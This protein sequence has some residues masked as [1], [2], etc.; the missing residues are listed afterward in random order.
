MRLPT[1]FTALRY[2][3]YRR[4]FIGQAL[5]LMGTWMQSVAQGWLVYEITGSK[6]ALGTISFAGSIPTLLLMLPAGVVADRLPRRKLLIATQTGMMLFAF[7]LAALAG[8]GVL[9]VWHIAVLAFLGGVANSFDAPARMALAVEMVDDR[10]DLQNAIALNATMF[11]LG[12]VLGPAIGGIILAALG[13]AWCFAI[14]GLS[15]VAVLVALAGMR[16]NERARPASKE[17]MIQQMKIGL[18][19]VWNHTALRTIMFLVAV[20]SIFGFS[21]SVLMPAYAADILQV[22]EAGLGGLNAAV[23]GGALIGSLVVASL[24]RSE[25]KGAQLTFGSLLFPVAVVAFALSQSF[26]VSLALLV[27]IGF[28]FVSQNSTSN[29]LV[30]GAAPDEL[31]GRVMSIYSLMLFGTMPF[32]SLLAGA[33]AQA[34]GPSVAVILCAGVTLSAALAVFLFAPEVRRLR[35]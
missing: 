10:R 24:T 34:L 7:V 27:I 13:A 26:A 28:A 9:Q 18:R 32:G 31:R 16:I 4:W 35:M 6:L 19:Y 23:G 21:Y 25:R 11:N 12:R 1:T 8:T 2:P 17:P 5:S 29:T 22:G 20:S 15:F 30:Q 33:L 14:N 3:N